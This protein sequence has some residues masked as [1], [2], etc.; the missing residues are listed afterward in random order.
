[1]GAKPGRMKGNKQEAE[2]LETEEKHGKPGKT[3][4]EE[5][6]SRKTEGQHLKSYCEAKQGR[7]GNEETEAE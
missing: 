5:Q 7:K 1:M 2:Y 4:V 3:E 6:G